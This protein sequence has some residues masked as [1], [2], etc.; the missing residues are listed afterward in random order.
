MFGAVLLLPFQL[1][2]LGKPS[3][4]VTPDQPAV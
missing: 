2:V 3:P 4:S 1:G